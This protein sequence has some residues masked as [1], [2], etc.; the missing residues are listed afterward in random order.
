MITA[1]LI[2]VLSAFN[3]I[4]SKIGK[5]Y[6]DFDPDLTITS[7]N[8]KTFQED[9]INYELLKTC[10]GVVTWSKAIEEL[11]VVKHE[12]K[13][14]NAKLI[15]VEDAYLDMS[16]VKTANHLIQ[17]KAKL[18]EG[19]LPLAL[20]GGSLLDKL[21]GHIPRLEGYENVKLFT[22][23]R[24]AK[25]RAGANPFYE[26]NINIA[27]KITYNRQVDAEVIIVPLTF[28]K[29]FLQYKKA[30]SAIF[31]D[32][33]STAD[34]ETVKNELQQ[35][36]G[37]NFDIKTKLEKNELI[38][39]TSKTEKII[40]FII[41]IFIFILAAFNLIASITMLFIEKK[42]NIKTMIAF[43]ASNKT[44]FN[45][46]YFEG[47][48]ISFKGIVIGLILGYGT[49][50]WQLYKPIIWLDKNDPFPVDFSLIDFF[51]ILGS[52]I[53]LSI[54]FSFSTVKILVKKHFSKGFS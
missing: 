19:K 17:G 45:I 40:V 23:K 52:V 48:M 21:E 9:E 53:L 24:D 4:E 33:D 30:I 49:C 14:I 47:L 28:G 13:W 39:K 50:F 32:V 38:F 11:I 6:S 5:L 18:A 44:I 36:L 16:K 2:I 37:N 10:T 1:A 20:I 22:P 8:G 7:K 31:V 27:G 25:L 46:F 41:L 3:G 43:G 29:D 12:K 26:T 54:F 35:K 15:A 34:N 51:L 42:E